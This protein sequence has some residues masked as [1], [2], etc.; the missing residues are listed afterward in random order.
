V[1]EIREIAP[2]TSGVYG[3][4]YTQQQV[5]DIF[6]VHHDTIV[7]WRQHGKIGGIRLGWRTV[8]IPQ[9]EI[10]RITSQLEKGTFHAQGAPRIDAATSPLRFARNLGAAIAA[11]GAGETHEDYDDAGGEAGPSGGHEDDDDNDLGSAG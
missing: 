3:P 5:A 9:S 1:A 4:Y 6:G 8:R 10:D 7:Y 2:G 11:S